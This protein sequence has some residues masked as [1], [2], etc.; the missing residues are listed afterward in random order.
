MTSITVAHGEMVGP[1]GRARANLHCVD[2]T[3]TYV[4]LEMPPADHTIDASG[5]LV[6]PGGVD[7][8]V[9]LMDP[10]DTER[11]DFPTGTAAAAARGVTTIVEHTHSHPVRSSDD[12]AAKRRHLAGRSNVDFGLAAHV[13][14]DRLH[15]LEGLW[16]A[17]ITFYKAFTCTT[18]GVPGLTPADIAS[19]VST[20]GGFGGTMLIHCEDETLTEAAEKR[21]RA[22]GRDDGGL[23]TEWRSREAELVAI[24]ATGVLVQLSG[25]KAT[26]AHVSNPAALQLVTE[27]RSRGADV[28]AEACPQ[29]LTLH[30]AEVEEQGALRKFTPP[31]RLRSDEEEETMWELLSEGAFGHV[32]TDHAPSTLQQK[33]SGDIWEAPFG[34]PGLDTTYPFLVDAALRGRLSLSRVVELYCAAPARRYGLGSTKGHLG[35][36]ADADFVLVDPAATWTIER[37]DIISK[38]GWSPYEG[39]TLHGRVTATYLRGSQI[40]ADGTCHG[41]GSGRFLPGPGAGGEVEP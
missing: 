15:D 19:A 27:A 28:V 16:H 34:L 39:R 9:H 37:S 20:I 1:S 17:G 24:A 40:A 25:V 32:S 10:G 3:V 6:L 38:A 18:H 30:E 26:F 2:G 13:W 21:L 4:G 5:L 8:H 22:A 11:E 36:G 35:V 29:Y 41:L 23:L 7:T 14:P 33:L 31:A 12:L